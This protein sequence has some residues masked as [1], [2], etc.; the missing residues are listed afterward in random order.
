MRFHHVHKSLLTIVFMVTPLSMSPPNASFAVKASI[1]QQTCNV[2]SLKSAIQHNLSLR[3]RY[4]HKNVE[5][6]KVVVCHH[7]VNDVDRVLYTFTLDQKPC[8]GLSRVYRK[9][10]HSILILGGSSGQ[11]VQDRK[12]TRLL[13]WGEKNATIYGQIND[14]SIVKVRVKLGGVPLLE[15]SVSGKSFYL[16]DMPFVLKDMTEYQY[17]Y[18]EGIDNT[19]RSVGD[20]KL[21]NLKYDNLLLRS[22]A[23]FHGVM[24]RMKWY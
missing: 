8:F 6:I 23:F 5:N 14:P 9:A 17:M 4:R 11:L 7:N 21:K 3:Y 16:I 12:L 15:E 18:T 24:A 13:E 10:N 20:T 22:K 2:S 19:G 1:Q